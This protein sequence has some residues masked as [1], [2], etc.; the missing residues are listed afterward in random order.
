MGEF[1]DCWADNIGLVLAQVQNGYRFVPDFSA[2]S[3]RINLL[4]AQRGV[5][6][7]GETP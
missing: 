7:Q 3:L 1:T 6:K 2:R 4:F 5:S